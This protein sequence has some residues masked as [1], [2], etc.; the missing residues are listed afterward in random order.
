MQICNKYLNTNNVLSGCK[1]IGTVLVAAGITTVLGAGLKA[2]GAK[3]VGYA[4]NGGQIKDVAFKHIGNVSQAI[5]SVAFVGGKAV[6]YSILIPAYAVGY[7]FPKWIINEGVPKAYGFGRD[8]IV[9][10]LV[11][12]VLSAA[13][14]VGNK[15]VDT[16]ILVN[17]SVLQPFF[18][19]VA[20]FSRSTV[21]SVIAFSGKAYEF[22]RN[23]VI[24]P[25]A[26]YV[27]NTA[28]YGYDAVA[29]GATAFAGHVAVIA[30]EVNAFVK[31]RT[32]T[33]CAAASKVYDYVS[34]DVSSVLHTIR[35]VK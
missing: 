23:R 25:A 21:N 11:P 2:G 28:K 10:P 30:R 15:F 35:G 16:S 34:K 22:G 24:I 13:K 29:K 19:G 18:K 6:A 20:N 1:I 17:N 32:T 3:L 31:A 26:S 33:I 7:L 14:F 4:G 12:K 9:T 5:G 27:A 8:H